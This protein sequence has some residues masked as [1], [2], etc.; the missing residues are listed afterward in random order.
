VEQIAEG[1]PKGESFTLMTAPV[2]RRAI[3][4]PYEPM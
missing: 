2:V 4:P 3:A 1:N